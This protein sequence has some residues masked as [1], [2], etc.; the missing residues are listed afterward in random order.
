MLLL[1]S[2][3]KLVAE[4]ALMAGQ[5]LVHGVDEEQVGLARTQAAQ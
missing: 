1:I 4:I 2:I 5:G 3:L